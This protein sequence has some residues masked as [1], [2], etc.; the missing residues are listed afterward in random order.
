MKK[1]I[2][3][4]LLV[5][6][7]LHAESMVS[8]QDEDILAKKLFEKAF[9]KKVKEKNF[10]LPF[11]VNNILQ[12][13]IFVKIDKDDNLFIS[14]ETLKY[15]ASLL[16]DEYQAQFDFT[17]DKKEY[18]P[19]NALNQ[20]GIKA[21]YDSRNILINVQL[22]VN[23]KKAHLLNFNRHR[24]RD[25][26][27]SIAPQKY[28]GGMNL[29]INQN[30]GN[31]S[32]SDSLER[33]PL[34]ASS[35]IVLNVHDFVLEGRIQYRESAENNKLSRDRVRL[36]KDDESNSLRYTVGDIML[37]A[38]TRMSYKDVL[39]VAVEKKFNIGMGSSYTRNISK[40]NSYEFF[41]KNQSRVEIFI[42][43]RYRN[44]L[45]LIAGTYNF[46]DL[47][48]PSGVNRVKL[49]IIEEGGKIEYLE[50]DDFSYNELLKKGTAKYGFG[51][52]VV[53]NR[54]SDNRWEYETDKQLA[55]G[56]IEYGLTDNLTVESGL[57]GGEDYISGD[58]E[59][60][61][62]T[63]FGLFNPY[64]IMSQ[65][66]ELEG[67]KQGIDYRTN[68]GKTNLNLG[69]EK[70]DEE[71]RTLNNFASE[72]SSS[73]TLYRANLYTPLGF[74]VNMGLST[75]QYEQNNETENKYGLTLSKS[76]GKLIARVDFDRIEE[77][78]EKRDD[79][80]YFTLDYRLGE[81]RYKYA[82]YVNDDK[83][84]FNFGYTP[85]GRYGTSA[86]LMYENSKTSDKYD[87]RAMMYDEKFKLDTSYTLT[88]NENSKYKNQSLGLRLATGFV[89]AG[90]TATITT[91]ISSSFIIIDNDDKIETP[92]GIEGYQG[93]DAL[94][95]DTFALSTGNY[96]NKKLI[97][98]EAELNF[99]IDLL[100]PEQKF[101]T[102]YRT[103][104][105]MEIAIENLYSV[106]GFFYDKKNKEP[107]KFKAF[108]IFNTQ[109]GERS[110][111]FSNENG[112]FTLNRVQAGHYN[113]TFMK[114]RGY[115]G[116]ARYSFD[117]K[118]EENQERLMNLGAVYIEMPKKKESKK[119]LVYNKK[120]NKIISA[121]FNSIL[122]NIYFDTNSYALSSKAKNKLDAI[123]NE[124]QKY[125]D[126]K[127]D[128]IGHSDITGNE[129]YN[130]E[131]SYR[132]A[133]SVKS[134]L[135]KK[136]IDS[137]QLNTLGMGETQPLSDDQ[138]QNRRAEFKGQVQFQVR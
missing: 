39:G 43:D 56:Y 134:Y 20:M 23:L 10:Y 96:Q 29:Y 8:N 75:S 30:Y 84:Q 82:N 33:K 129:D 95:Y 46:Y 123:A 50:F 63:N 119:Y 127:L 45:N 57:Q 41:I 18:T 122:Q 73:S 112:E 12:D 89:F 61:Y 120:S 136:G 135:D 124:L 51:V 59:L 107:L 22:P 24:N 25:I 28:S 35:D 109:T 6:H 138:S 3:L 106:K 91:P 31:P 62:G 85:K 4:S 11:K 69:Y 9:K 1:E 27:G 70:R 34:S 117:I 2:L 132:R 111:S 40:I 87:A 58:M 118:E 44:A 15:V 114:E 52:G 60:I 38:H 101:I 48:L 65:V 36:V 76:F 71:Y 125:K 97:V 26:N 93:D 128:I 88:D 37:P 83:Q 49:K 102:N 47:D 17:V 19:L 103:G 105:V 5:V 68:I 13:E 100:N 110:N 55:S 21:E 14:L 86:N 130:M 92:L 81:T 7:L 121:T 108:K 131:L 78:G 54:D 99:G 74:G 115:E 104:S 126:I 77:E 66:D 80:V 116:V 53:S 42:N 137:L 64:I 67:Y 16:K 32:S 113:I 98:N 94:T 72:T 90:D 79:I 133:N